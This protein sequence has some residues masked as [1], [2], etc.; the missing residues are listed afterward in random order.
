MTN[1]QILAAL[2]EILGDLLGADDLVLT[3]AT[4]REDVPDWDSL[5]YV[6]FIAMVEIRFGIKFNVSEIESFQDIGAVVS[7]VQAK[8]AV[9]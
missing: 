5:M 9:K 8:L 6:N 2:A 7:G 3:S 1:D 4:R